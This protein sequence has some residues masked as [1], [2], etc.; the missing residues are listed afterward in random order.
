[1]RLFT[2]CLLALFPLLTWNLTQQP[3]TPPPPLA[4][5]SYENNE[6]T[7]YLYDFKTRK[8]TAVPRTRPDTQRN[9]MFYGYS[10]PPT[11]IS[12]FSPYDPALRFV[13]VDESDPDSD[14]VEDGYSLYRLHTGKPRE[15]ITAHVW[16]GEY[17]YWSPDGRYLYISPYAEDGESTALERYEIATHQLVELTLAGGRMLSCDGSNVWCAY[18]HTTGE[19]KNAVQTLYL[20]N[21]NTSDIA[22]IDT[23]E[24]MHYIPFYWQ[25]GTPTFIYVLPAAEMQTVHLYNYETQTDQI[26]FSAVMNEVQ[27]AVRS[28]DGR[29]L[30][31]TL[32]RRDVSGAD[33]MLVDLAAPNPTLKSLSGPS[34]DAG[35]VDQFPLQWLDGYGLLYELE[36]GDEPGLYLLQPGSDPRKLLPLKG[37]FVYDYALSPDGAWLA[38]LAEGVSYPRKP[39][40]IPLGGGDPVD[41]PIP[42]SF[43]NADCIGWVSEAESK[44][45]TAYLCDK[46]WGEG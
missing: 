8:I 21:K 5:S 29:W 45:G 31:L 28:P 37:A 3:T 10:L 44:S 33:I 26:L 11:V 25:A 30:A 27:E 35:Y 41:V 22:S 18:R 40:V 46:Y 15:F 20:F 16:T 6:N 13:M 7:Y 43:Q 24:T 9:G 1:M 12:F 23:L 38:V 36:H 2:L 39:I 14:D 19:G 32:D 34:G 4:M 17:S 42:S